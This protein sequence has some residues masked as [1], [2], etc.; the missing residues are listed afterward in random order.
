MK[1]QMLNK[2]ALALAITAALPGMSLAAD[3]AVQIGTVKVMPAVKVSYGHDDNVAA[4]NAAIS[5]DVI[6][7]EPSIALTTKYGSGSYFLN[8]RIKDDRYNDHSSYDNTDHD[9]TAGAN[10]KPTKRVGLDIGAGFQKLQAVPSS[11]N[12]SAGQ[13]GDKHEDVSVD[14]KLSYGA[15]GAKGRFDVYAGYKDVEYTN[16]R[17]AGTQTKFKD[18]DVNKLGGTFFYKVMPKTSA[19]INV[20]FNDYSYDQVD[21]A[22]VNLDSETIAYKVGLTGEATAKT[23]G[24]IKVGR[25]EKDFDSASVSD[26]S[27]TS[28]DV[29]VT[30]K[31]KS[32]SKVTLSA[33]KG[34]DE[35]S[36]TEHFIKT[37]SVSVAWDHTWS[38]KVKSRLNYGLTNK[39][40]TGDTNA[41]RSDD[42]TNYGASV[43]Y[44]L[45]R[46]ASVDLG[47][48]FSE[49]DAS[50]GFNSSDYD[51]SIYT[52][53]LNAKL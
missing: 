50:A 43:S 1:I 12:T 47:Y 41:G 7:I 29:S 30:W 4:A 42:V 5:D 31:P 48:K 40:Y 16:N 10:L 53:G 32:Y 46:W 13:V 36:T 2:S 8:Y 21:S 6:T 51:R 27:A 18:H 11:T 38:S 9:L 24:T 3:D 25:M 17:D 37:D 35:G 22:G 26:P 44:K 45:N 15:E 28:Y 23:E 34:F 33:G 49:T 52:V 20:E 14:G 19:L 39:D